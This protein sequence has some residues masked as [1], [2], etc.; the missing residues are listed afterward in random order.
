MSQLNAPPAGCRGLIGAGGIGS[1]A[2]FAL[3]GDH[4]LGREESRGGHF[5]DQRDYCKLHIIAHT[6]KQ[7]MGAG[8]EA[9]LIG[10]VG[11]DSAGRDLLLEMVEAGLD[12]RYVNLVHGAQTLYSF[13]FV[14]PDGSGGNMST[15]D[16]AN[17][18]VDGEFVA[19]AAPEFQRLAG[20]GVVLAAPE[21]PLDARMRLL[22]LGTQH[23]MWRA[24]SLTSEECCAPQAEPMLRMADLLALNLDEAAALADSDSGSNPERIA[25]G[26]IERLRQLK[27]NMLVS[28]T[29]GSQGS[30]SW[31]GTTLRYL[32]AF[33]V[34]LVSSAG[35]GDA[36]LAAMIAGLVSG[37]DMQHA[38]ELANL[39]AAFKVRSPHTINP[40]LNR[41]ALRPFAAE[42]GAVL[43][44][45]VTQLLAQMSTDAQERDDVRYP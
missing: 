31:D 27:P 4:T 38:Q 14:Y 2:F 9:V 29:A 41:L 6:V 17:S 39:A 42:I 25:R 20:K 32:P 15:D 45:P 35:A 22:E 26:A 19:T 16:S 13:C 24:L 11:D 7:L 3:S 1:G 37:L 30:Y 43:S 10:K 33:Q 40:D 34:K 8:F 23:R 44:A 5:L 36:H 18:L 28:I 12:T 21:V